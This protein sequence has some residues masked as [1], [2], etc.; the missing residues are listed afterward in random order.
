MHIPNRSVN[1]YWYP[2]QTNETVD[3]LVVLSDGAT[4]WAITPP[5]GASDGNFTI[6][7]APTG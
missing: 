4:A 2:F 5:G 1:K 3:K 7:Q 6:V